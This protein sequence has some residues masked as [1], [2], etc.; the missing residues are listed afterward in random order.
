VPNPA[1]GP[2]YDGRVTILRLASWNICRGR[3]RDRDR[4]DLDLVLAAL[5]AL[6]ADVV[7]LQEVDRDQQES[8]ASHQARVLAEALG[9]DWRYAPTLLGTVGP[10]PIAGRPATPA[11]P[12]AEGD[13]GPAYGIALLSRRP[14]RRSR[15]LP[16]PQGRA[17]E[18]RVALLTEV[19]TDAGPVTVAGTHLANS[20][21]AN[22][23]QLR[24]LQRELSGWP[25][26]R[27]LLGDLNL[28]L[29]LVRLLS[30]PGWRP[31]VRGGTW[32]N[33]PPGEPG[34]TV[35]LDHVLAHG[36]GLRPGRSRVHAGLA[37]DHRA[38]LAEV[39][40]VPAPLR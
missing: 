28:W 5:R 38:V 23:R 6:D 24:F 33:R 29:P 11:G 14:F 40:V 16:L 18:P 12:G 27:L 35:Q 26:P 9:M 8:G 31:L 19:P 21:P 13:D 25:A 37:S 20:F 22:A 7:A 30:R 10:G 39:E 17:S 32:R 15:T 1:P 2:G 34:W 36:G 3:T 4:F